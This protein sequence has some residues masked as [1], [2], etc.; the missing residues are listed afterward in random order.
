VR[1]GLDAV[2]HPRL[3]QSVSADARAGVPQLACMMAP[4][5]HAC[6]ITFIIIWNS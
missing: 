6:C 5:P 2:R 1:R 3:V 4:L